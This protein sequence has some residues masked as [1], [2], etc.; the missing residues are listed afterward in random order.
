M[1]AVTAVLPLLASVL[2]PV[3]IRA[4]DTRTPT[5]T[6]KDWLSNLLPPPS[7]RRT[8]YSKSRRGPDIVP[9]SAQRFGSTTGHRHYIGTYSITKMKQNQKAWQPLFRTLLQCI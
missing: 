4:Q 1:V 3:G 6:M 8:E 5:P 7:P 9:V 2:L